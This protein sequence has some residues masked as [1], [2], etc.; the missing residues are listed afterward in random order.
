MTDTSMDGRVDARRLYFPGLAG[1]YQSI[2]PYSYALIRFG[3]GVILLYHGYGK[4]F[5]GAAAPVAQNVLAP[6]GF[7]APLAWAYFLGILELFGGAALALGL[8]TRLIALM[9]IVQF[10]FVTYWHS[11]NGYMFTSPRGGWEFPAIMLLIYVAIFFRG[12]GR[13]SIDRAIGKEL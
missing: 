8:F 2:A 7:P 10:I 13:C 4:L 11:K 5:M 3:A 6:L 12:G 9:L 1:L